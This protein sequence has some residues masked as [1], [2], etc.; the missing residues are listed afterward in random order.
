MGIFRHGGRMPR[1]EFVQRMQKQLG[2]KNAKD[3]LVR[4]QKEHE[5]AV[6]ESQCENRWEQLR[7]EVKDTAKAIGNGMTY[8]DPQHG[9]GILAFHE[10]KMSIRFDHARCRITYECGPEFG[11]FKPVVLGDELRF[12]KEQKASG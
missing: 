6:L 7:Q 1:D 4:Q 11:A 12:I 3:A 9:E 8:S 2:E 10:R 5:A